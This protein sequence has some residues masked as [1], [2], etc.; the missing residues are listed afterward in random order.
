MARA[1][2]GTG[3]HVRSAPLA[4][5]VGAPGEHTVMMADFEGPILATLEADELTGL[6]NLTTSASSILWVISGGPLKGKLSEYGMTAGLARS[7][8]SENGWLDLATLDFDLKDTS[9]TDMVKI[10]TESADR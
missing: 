3:W 6:R 7:V 10:I 9:V 4:D 1:T 5:S 2:E 8:T